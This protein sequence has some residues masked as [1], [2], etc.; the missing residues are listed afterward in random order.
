VTSI[1]IGQ[2]ITLGQG[3]TLK[4]TGSLIRIVLTSSSGTTWTVPS[5]FTSNNTVE[6][7]GKGGFGGYANGGGGGGQPGT[8]S[9]HTGYDGLSLTITDYLGNTYDYLGG[10][11]GGAFHSYA[12]GGKGGGG[13]GGG[14]SGSS[15]LGGGYPGQGLILI[16]YHI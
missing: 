1:T 8:A 7:W 10:G 9:H 14:G 2:G 11:G 6:C 13:A 3:V 16:T 5:N 4:S 15:A 12:T